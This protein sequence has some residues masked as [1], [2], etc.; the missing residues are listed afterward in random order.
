MFK[1]KHMILYLYKF[2]ET[3]NTKGNLKTVKIVK[4]NFFFKFCIGEMFLRNN[5]NKINA[6]KKS[7]HTYSPKHNVRIRQTLVVC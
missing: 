7:N 4:M 2:Y 1:T 5:H 6:C 3:E